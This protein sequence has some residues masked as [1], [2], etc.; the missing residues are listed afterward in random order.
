MAGDHVDGT[1]VRKTSIVEK[2]KYVLVWDEVAA[3][4]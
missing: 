3:G 4:K 1:K 2:V